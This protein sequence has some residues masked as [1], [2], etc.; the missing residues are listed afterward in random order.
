[1]CVW[2]FVVS[3]AI[4]FALLL[5]TYVVF[6]TRQPGEGP[7]AASALNVSRTAVFSVFLIASSLTFW[8]A[9]RSLRADRL[10]SFLKW[11]GVT[12]FLGIVFL[13]GQAWEYAGLLTQGISIDRNL[14]ASTFFT[15]T[16]FHGLHVAAGLIVLAIMYALGKNKHVTSAQAQPF[17][18]I[19]VYWHFVD[20]VWMFV[21]ATVYLGAFLS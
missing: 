7:T 15:L 16:G 9:E 1:V 17:G 10:P 21:F 18:A 14:F 3:E 4:F 5:V 13:C 19:G 12:I 20:V 2:A 8:L 6:N 11:L